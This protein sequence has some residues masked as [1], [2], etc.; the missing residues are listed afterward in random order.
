M[1]K[2]TLEERILYSSTLKNK[3][4]GRIPV[5]IEKCK[6]DKSEFVI[7]RSKYLIP[8]EL[9]MAQFICLVRKRIKIDSRKAIFIFIDNVLL[10]M[11]Q[12]MGEI[13]NTHKDPDGFLYVTYRLENTFG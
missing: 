13:Y 1:E 2:K 10:P 11:N 12:T 6:H 5:I 9:D 4:P 3:Y 8:V 7:D